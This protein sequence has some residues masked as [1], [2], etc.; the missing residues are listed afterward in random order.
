M[1]KVQLRVGDHKDKL[2]GVPGLNLKQAMNH[3]VSPAEPWP[4]RWDLYHPDIMDDVVSISL[5]IEN[6]IITGFH[7]ICML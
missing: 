6:D 4:N 5:I 7:G 3:M 1:G 2:K